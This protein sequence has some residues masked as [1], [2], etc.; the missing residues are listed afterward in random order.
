MVGAPV[1]FAAAHA[2]PSLQYRT[3]TPAAV[4]TYQFCGLVWSIATV[5][6]S[7]VEI[8][9][10]AATV[11]AAPV[12]AVPFAPNPASSVAGSLGCCAKPTT[13][14]SDP[15]PPFKF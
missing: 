9:G 4:D 15:N 3:L 2:F 11:A 14:A 8:C 12:P 6:P 10:H 5:P 1:K 13:S 7:P